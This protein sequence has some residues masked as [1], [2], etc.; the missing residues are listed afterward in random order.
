MLSVHFETLA[1]GL[2]NVHS[3]SHSLFVRQDNKVLWMSLFC[4]GGGGF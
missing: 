4:G 2:V 3:V 1:G